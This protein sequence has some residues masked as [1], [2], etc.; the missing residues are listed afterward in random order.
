MRS[1]RN[2]PRAVGEAN[3]EPTAPGLPTSP[4]RMEPSTAIRLPSESR[5]SSRAE[6]LRSRQSVLGRSPSN[7]L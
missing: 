5:A 7:A 4:S 1:S 2:S 6:P 3:G